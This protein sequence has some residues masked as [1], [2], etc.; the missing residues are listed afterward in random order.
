M[1][2]RV[3]GE[4]IEDERFHRAFLE[5]SGG[6]TPEQVRQHAPSEFQST[7]HQAE[8]NVLRAVLLQQFAAAEGITATSQEVDE[9]RRDVWGST[10]NES[11]GIGVTQD[12]ADRIT[13]RKAEQFL[14]RHV[15][16]PDRSEVDSTCRA[17]P[18]AFALPERWLVSHIVK[19]VESSSEHDTALQ[20]M[21][22]VIA[23]LKRGRAFAAVAERY[24]DCKGN[25]GSL[26]WISRGSMVAAFEEHV[27]AL[28]RRK[29]SGI[30][31][32]P[33]GLHIAV[34]Q[35]H[36]DAGVQPLE[37]LRL[38]LSRRIYEERRQARLARV[39]NDLYRQAQI[40]PVTEMQRRVASGEKVS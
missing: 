35:D 21:T 27:F 30:F 1:A 12:M 26:G 3:N 9:E 38:S 17:N 31:E 5:Q 8:Q 14:T 22:V 16:R 18:S 39:L 36:K 33:F 13:L 15:Q 10:A 7:L 40:E 6:R 11:C 2:I 37:D 4:F 23:E 34:V 29:V 19:F 28:Q 25:G 24:S 32:T 20:V